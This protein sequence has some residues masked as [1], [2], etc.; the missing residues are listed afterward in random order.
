MS[1]RGFC[2]WREI[3]ARLDVTS[4]SLVTGDFIFKPLLFPLQKMRTLVAA[5]CC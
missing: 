3:G 1:N 2:S 4:L 5:S